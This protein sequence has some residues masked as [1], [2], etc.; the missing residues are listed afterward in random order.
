M[1][2][3][4]NIVLL[5]AFLV[6]VGS[7]WSLL[8]A[9]EGGGDTITAGPEG[10]IRLH[11]IANSDSPADQAV[12]YKVRDAVTAYLA[13]RLEGVASPAAARQIVADNRSQ[14]LAVARQTLDANGASYPASLEIG[15]FDFPLRTYGSLVLPPGRYEAVR[16]LLGDAAGQNWWCVL[17][18][19]LCF[20]DAATAVATP[21][22]GKAPAAG[23]VELR[24][25]IRES[26]YFPLNILPRPNDNI[27][28]DT[29]G[30]GESGTDA[31]GHQ[32]S[33]GQ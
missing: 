21:V 30:T 27:A 1:K 5:A 31:D 13:P 24:W 10:L 17:F 28:R 14:L 18:P 8:L 32:A 7:G 3:K 26:G 6:F 15:Y 12:K 11:I 16:I 19:P 29:I 9:G 4:L 22:A 33:A 20:I 23:R 2:K 25:K